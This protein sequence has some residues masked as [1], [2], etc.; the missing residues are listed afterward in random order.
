VW[1][2]FTR[3]RKTRVQENVLWVKRVFKEGM[4][5]EATHISLYDLKNGRCL[6]EFD[7]EPYGMNIIF[8]I[9]RAHR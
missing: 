8:S 5:E 9:F 2:G 3:V 1:V 7:L 4:V 6:E